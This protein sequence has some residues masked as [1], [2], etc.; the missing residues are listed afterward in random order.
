[1]TA[2]RTGRNFYFNA[3]RG[4]RKASAV[5]DYI[6]PPSLESLINDMAQVKS[7]GAILAG[8]TDLLVKIRTGL[9]SRRVLFD[10]NDLQEMNGILSEGNS[11]RIGAGTRIRDIADSDMVRDSVPFLALA[12]SELGSPQIRN[13]ATLGGNIV[14][15]SPSADTVPP[16]IAMGARLTFRSPEGDRVVSIED[17]LQ[18]PGQTTIREDEVLTGVIVPKL[19]NGSKSH[20]VKVGRRK[21]LAISVVNI[22]GWIKTDQA[23]FI[24]DAGLAL[25]A[26]APTA[27]RARR[28]EAFLK[29]KKPNRVVLEEA[30]RM[31]A[32]E[33]SPISDIRGEREGRRLLVEA[34]TFRLLESLTG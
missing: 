15:A 21:A 2:N 23:G 27:I 1:V 16:L 25:G 6:K 10:I 18:G 31:A 22:A 5:F 19:S 20:F 3:K 13:R 32:G 34:W 7:E 30:A 24:E 8:G 4:E 29:G 26:V 17:F 11:L 14:S 28:V 33:S 12:A 9:I